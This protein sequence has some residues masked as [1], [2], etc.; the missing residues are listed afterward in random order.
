METVNVL[1]QNPKPI[2]L[3]FHLGERGVSSIG[4]GASGAVFDFRK[5]FPGDLGASLEHRTG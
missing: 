1:G 2:E 5:V 3:W 4:A